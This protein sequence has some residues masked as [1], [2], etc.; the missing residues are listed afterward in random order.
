[1]RKSKIKKVMAAMMASMMLLGVAITANAADHNHDY[2]TTTNQ[3]CYNSYT[4]GSHPYTVVTA[5]GTQ[6]RSC[7]MVIYLYVANKKCI[8][9]NAIEEGVLVYSQKIQHMQCGRGWE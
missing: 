8:Y 1:M 4:A 9:C 2:A 5:E 7:D 6:Y 3:Y